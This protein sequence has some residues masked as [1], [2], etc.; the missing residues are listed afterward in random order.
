MISL[1][2]SIIQHTTF[3]MVPCPGNAID[4]AIR[5]ARGKAAGEVPG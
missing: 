4:Y 2:R 5:M 3:L 1:K